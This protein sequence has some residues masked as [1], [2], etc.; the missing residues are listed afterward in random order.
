M[1]DIILKYPTS[2]TYNSRVP[3]LQNKTKSWY[4]CGKAKDSDQTLPF[5]VTRSSS[6][7]CKEN[8]TRRVNF[9]PMNFQENHSNNDTILK[10][11]NYNSSQHRTSTLQ[12]R[13]HIFNEKDT[14]LSWACSSSLIRVQVAW[15]RF[16]WHS[17]NILLNTINYFTTSRLSPSTVQPLSGLHIKFQEG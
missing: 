11:Q 14:R 12:F 5:L 4:N 10:P 8:K 17:V 7:P 9:R 1:I 13:I 3:N 2:S 15:L 6:R 16:C